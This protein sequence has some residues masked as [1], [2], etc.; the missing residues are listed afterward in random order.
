MPS[1]AEVLYVAQ[2]Q[3]GTVAGPGNTTPYSAWYQ[4]TYPLSGND[5]QG[6]NW[7]AIFVSWVW[8][9]GRLGLQF[10][11]VPSGVAA[12]KFY[13]LFDE[14]PRPGDAVFYDWN[15]DGQADHVGL[16]EVVWGNN[17]QT[18]EGNAGTPPGVYRHLIGPGGDRE[19]TDVLGYG[20]PV[21]T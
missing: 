7:C 6:E 16:V 1:C 17:V 4:Q 20:H 8:N 9:R 12:F 15:G 21:Y 13:G 10:A 5:Y 11:W 19:Y 18:I 14:H 3:V 2:S